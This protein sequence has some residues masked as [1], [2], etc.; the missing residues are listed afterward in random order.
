MDDASRE[1]KAFLLRSG[2]RMKRAA[3]DAAGPEQVVRW[4]REAVEL[5]VE[6]LTHLIENPACP[7]AATHLLRVATTIDVALQPLLE[8]LAQDYE[9]GMELL[10]MRLCEAV[11]KRVAVRMAE[12]EAER[13][14]DDKRGG[15]HA[16]H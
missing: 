15:E 4:T 3:A 2:D 16:T 12:V 14:K 6:A 7:M 8:A 5:A 9:G 13:T 10:R 1:A 11:D